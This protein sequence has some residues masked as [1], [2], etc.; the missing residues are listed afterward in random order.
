MVD[1]PSQLCKKLIG[2]LCPKH[3]KLVNCCAAD[4][5]SGMWR[6]KLP[7][8]VKAAVAN[9]NLSGDD[10]ENTL[11]QADAVYASTL[12]V[13][14]I[15]AIAPAGAAGG[16]SANGASA[17][18]GGATAEVAAVKKVQKGGNKQ[19]KKPKGPHPDGPPEN[20]CKMHRQF[21]KSAY[22]CTAPHSCPWHNYTTPRPSKK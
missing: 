21:G 13:G 17:S 1:K 7:P 15:A 11:R 9:Y 2:I 22:F 3:P 16:K 18:S 12:T 20:C 8:V 6:D 10:L 4:I 19:Q 5:I 14:Q